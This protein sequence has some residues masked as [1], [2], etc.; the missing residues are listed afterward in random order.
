[1]PGASPVI[2]ISHSLWQRRFG[3]SDT[4]IG[5]SVTVNGAPF[6]I[7]GVGPAGFHGVNSLFGPDG[8][9]PTM[10]YGQ[11]LPAQFRTWMNERRALV[12]T[13]AGRLKPG[14]TIDQARANLVSVAKSLERR[15]RT[16]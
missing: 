13:L 10:M 12:F 11:V 3:G 16:Q 1:M 15:I 4:V 5:R 2:V 6:T 7:I 9:V 14:T 8:W